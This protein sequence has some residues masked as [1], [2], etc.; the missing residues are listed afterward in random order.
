MEK[1]AHILRHCMNFLFVELLWLIYHLVMLCDGPDM[2]KVSKQSFASLFRANY[3]AVYVSSRRY[4]PI[5]STKSLIELLETQ[6]V[7]QPRFE[8]DTS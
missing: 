2:Y 4:Y 6:P 8:A 1:M 3:F 7:S 5:I